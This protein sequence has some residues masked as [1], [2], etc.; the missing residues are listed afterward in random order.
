MELFKRLAIGTA[1]FGQDYHGTRCK[2]ID[3]VLDYCQCVG[4][5]ML[6]TAEAYNWDYTKVGGYFKIVSKV[7]KISHPDKPGGIIE[8][9]PSKLYG[10]LVHNSTSQ[11]VLDIIKNFRPER[12]QKIGYSLYEFPPIDIQIDIIQIP[13]SLW[14]RRFEQ[15]IEICHKKGIEVHIRS[16]FLQGKILQ[17]GKA[18]A[19]DCIAFALMNP[20]VDRVII[21]VDSLDQLKG[22]LDYFCKLDLMKKDDLNLI[23]PRR[24]K[25]NE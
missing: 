12:Y 13:Y 20:Y 5:D 24:W 23:D 3:A 7:R 2:N 19:K 17:E 1:N 18:D 10:C 14:D 6:D 16:V 8:I 15:T 11:F 21:G 4:I 25:E 9:P 22:N